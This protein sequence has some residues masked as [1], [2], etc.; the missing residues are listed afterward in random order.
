MRSLAVIIM[1]TLVAVAG[2]AAQSNTAEITG[3]VRDVRPGSRQSCLLGRR[4]LGALQGGG[5]RRFDGCL[6]SDRRW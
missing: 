2:A 6:G 3:I 4:N 1:S 5:R